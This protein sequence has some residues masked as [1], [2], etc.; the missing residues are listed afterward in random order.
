MIQCEFENGDKARLRH[1][2]IDAI[3]LKE[4]NILLV[5]RAKELVEG[6]KWALVGGFVDR[7]ERIKDAVEREVLEE[8]GWKVENVQF[9]EINDSPKRR[10]DDRQN[11]AFVFFCDAKEQIGKPDWE[12]EDQKWYSFDEL[13][14]DEELAFDHKEF[15]DRY[16]NKKKRK[17]EYKYE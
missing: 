2:I 3:V 13:P 15:I 11:I 10:N 5:K 16:I 6:G 12:S 8:T 14:S 4:E 1:V 17:V 9:L 7:D